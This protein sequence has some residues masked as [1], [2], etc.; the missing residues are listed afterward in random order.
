MVQEL[1]KIKHFIYLQ[2]QIF[3]IQKNFKQEEVKKIK[4]KLILIQYQENKVDLNIHKGI[5]LS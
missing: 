3:K 4:L 1:I 2:V 5:Y